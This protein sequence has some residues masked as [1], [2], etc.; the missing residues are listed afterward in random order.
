VKTRDFGASGHL[1]DGRLG[2]VLNGDGG[3]RMGALTLELI[4]R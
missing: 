3:P 2:A 4:N 1:A